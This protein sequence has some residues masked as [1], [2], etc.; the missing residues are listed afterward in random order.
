MTNLQIYEGND[1]TYT[2]TIT[3]GDDVAIDITGYEI[4]FTVKKKITDS[5][6]DAII[7]KNVTSHIDPTNGITNIT[8]SRAD[9]KDVKPAFYPYDIQMCTDIDDRITVLT[10]LYEIKQSVGDREC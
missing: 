9:T 5:D 3:D 2:L 4:L 10:G 8:V 6:N 1:K 7:S